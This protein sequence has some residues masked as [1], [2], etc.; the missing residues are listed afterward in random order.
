MSALRR[1]GLVLLAGLILGAIFSWPLPRYFASG[2]AS[3]ASNV[4]KDNVRAMI[5]GDHLQF[6]YHLWLAQ[7]TFIGPT[8][9]FHNLYEFN[10]GADA[11][12]REV[13]PYYL[14]FSLFFTAGSLIGGRAFGWNLAIL[15]T[16]WITAWFS[17]KLARRYVADEWVAAMLALVPLAFPFQWIVWLSGSPTG[18]AMMWVPILLYGIDRWIADKSAAGAAL[19]GAAVF[20][21]EWSDTHVFFFSVL[22]SPVWVLFSYLLRHGFRWPSKADWRGWLRSS[23]VLIL[24]IAL[25]AIKAMGVQQGLQGT[26]I[27][28]G[29]PLHEINLFSHG[30]A[31]LLD[32]GRAG[33]KIYV[34]YWGVLLLGAAFFRGFGQIVRRRKDAAGWGLMLLILGIVGIFLLSTGTKNPLGP[35]AWAA[36][37][38]LVP[39]YGMI[40]QPD[41]IFCILPALILVAAALAFRNAG[42][43]ERKWPARLVCAVLLLPLLF[44]FGARLDPTVCLL[45]DRQGAYEAVAAHA[46]AEGVKPRALVIPLWPGDSHY[47]S[48]YQHDVS[49]YRI[50]M[51][52]GYR[53]TARQKY[54]DEIF[55]PFQSL[56][57][58]WP[59]D[60]QLDALLARGIDHLILHEDVFPEKVSSFPVDVTL[61]NLLGHPR[62]DRLAHD[63]PVW[64]FAIRKKPATRLPGEGAPEI[65]VLFPVRYW[66]W[67]QSEWPTGEIRD[68]ADAI[69]GRF[70]R[71]AGP[72]ANSVSSRW[73]RTAG[74]IPMEWHVRV[75]G[76][77]TLDLEMQV[78]PG[79]TSTETRRVDAKDWTWVRVAVPGIHLSARQTARVRVAEGVLD[80][81]AM[82]LTRA[83]WVPPAPGET[84]MIPAACFFRA[85]Y[86]LDDF[87]GIAFRR[88]RDPNAVIFY[89]RHLYL[90][91]GTYRVWAEIT[92]DAAPGT[93]LGALVMRPG[94]DGAPDHR[95]SVRSGEKAVIEHVQ[96]DNSFFYFGF[97]YARNADLVIHAVFFERVGGE[98][99]KLAVP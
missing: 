58:G 63:G 92:T 73:I 39:P 40:R 96:P 49:L 76:T 28:A 54:I 78:D 16:W 75:R 59:D 90:E 35:R 3:S 71:V 87:S 10:T 41:K 83:G 24:F 88:D 64:S 7:D 19:A 69:G 27:A 23:W 72:M 70:A 98:V 20:F 31:G 55:E 89:S 25:A 8:P 62:L 34:G 43:G 11:E 48:L 61:A 68:A 37:M 66:E 50:R 29:R 21:S 1:I 67:E 74:P 44:D 33:G 51:V 22:L 12:R 80:L 6:L 17:W 5:P 95:V 84:K 82:I 2:I 36:W 26:A 13:R 30:L 4:E 15:I 46:R 53:P 14:P 38:K 57:S 91:P 47:S 18:F 42:T 85:G 94:P 86:S 77:G 81:D 65:P 52:N 79:G 93:E 45:D 97:D 32:P 56:N 60:A 99:D 9:L